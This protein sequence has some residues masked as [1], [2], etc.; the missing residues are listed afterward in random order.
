[1]Q[2][3][4]RLEHLQEK[5][6]RANGTAYVTADNIETRRAVGRPKGPRL[7]FAVYESLLAYLALRAA[8]SREREKGVSP[9]PR[10]WA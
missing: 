8:F 4:G 10:V 5:T 1:L 7:D 3:T 6:R 9:L 2:K